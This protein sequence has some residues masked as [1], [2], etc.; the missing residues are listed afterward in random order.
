MSPSL[1]RRKWGSEKGGVFPKDPRLAGSR[2]GIQ[3]QAH[4]TPDYLEL[5]WLCPEAAPLLSAVRPKS[6]L[7]LHGFTPQLWPYLK[8]WVG[9]WVAQSIKRLPSAQVT[10]L[11]SWD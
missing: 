9:A 8:L 6:W 4:G 7:P 3:S 11:G 10:T 2:A 1:E 5:P